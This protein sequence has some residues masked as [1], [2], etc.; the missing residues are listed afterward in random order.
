MIGPPELVHVDQK[1]TDIPAMVT[2]RAGQG[3]ITWIPWD[4]AGLYYKLSLPAHA[5]LF[6]DV[7]SRLIATPQLRTDAHPLVEMT[8]M[9]QGSRTLLHLINLSG[10]ADTGYYAP[11][12]MK[13]I[14]VAVAGSFANAKTVRESG[15]LPVRRSA[16]YSE[17]VIPALR[18]YELVVL[19]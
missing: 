19:Q 14:H 4:L 1:D 5:G 2:R 16:G 3:S 9:R 11:I 12:P 17:I 18:D 13:D 7:V 10:H 6:R 8:L 15:V